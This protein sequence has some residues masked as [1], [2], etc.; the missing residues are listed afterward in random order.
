MGPEL[1]QKWSLKM[2]DIGTGST[3]AS[4]FLQWLVF[5]TFMFYTSCL[6]I[7]KYL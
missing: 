4:H 6:I 5:E 1:P 7:E 3:V 2:E